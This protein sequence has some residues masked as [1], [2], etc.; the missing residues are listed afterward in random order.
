MNKD[1]LIVQIL[2][3]TQDVTFVYNEKCA[4][5]NPWNENKF[6]VGFGDIVK[7]YTDI[8]DLMNDPIYDGKTLS[9]ICEKLDIELV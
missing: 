2:S 1:D 6:E 3:L 9:Q 5:I 7:S 4:C 8:D